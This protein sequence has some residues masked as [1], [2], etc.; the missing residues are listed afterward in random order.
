MA[1]KLDTIDLPHG[2]TWS[3]RYSWTPVIQNVTVTVT[4]SIVVQ[5]AVQLSGRPIT[6]KGGIDVCWTTKSVIDALYAKTQ[7][8]SSVMTLDLTDLGAGA[9]QVLWRRGEE[10]LEVVP[11]VTSP[12]EDANTL[13]S[14][15]TLRFL[16]VD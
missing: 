9:F 8:A 12:Y 15:I 11:L 3:D 2:L 14:I 6:L 16:K 13:Y 1:L 4:G 7:A 10:P 5:E